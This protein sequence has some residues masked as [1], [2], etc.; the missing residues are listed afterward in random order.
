MFEKLNI[1]HFY[2]AHVTALSKIV[3]HRQEINAINVFPVADAD[4]GNNMAATALAVIH[5]ATMANTLKDTALNMAKA[6]L[7]GARGNSGMIFSQY[8]SGM[9]EA[10]DNEIE[11]DINTFAN[12]ITKAAQ[13][14]RMAI[15][16]PVE[17][18][19]LTLMERFAVLL[20]QQ[21]QEKN[22]EKAI[23][24]CANELKNTLDNTKNMLKILHDAN[25]VDAGALGFYE[26][27]LGMSEY[28]SHPKPLDRANI[29]DVLVHEH[30]ELPAGDEPPKYRYC[31]ELLL[32]GEHLDR[33]A[34]SDELSH[35]GDSVVSS[36][37]QSLCRFHLH[38]NQPHQVFDF[39]RQ[40]GLISRPKIDD[41][42]RQFQVA[43]HKKH[44]I[45]LM[46]DSSA[47][48]PQ[49][50]IDE[51]Q[52]HVLSLNMH[53]DNHDLLDK[54]C[55]DQSHFYQDLAKLKHYPG[56]SFPSPKII[57]D[58]INQVAAHY[59][60]LIILPLSRGLS[61][62][63]DAIVSAAANQHH[64]HVIDSKNTS[65]GLGLLVLKAARLIQSGVSIDNIIDT[66]KHDIT[67]TH[68]FVY[69]HQM[70]G[71]LRSGRIGRLGAAIA[72]LANVKPIISI[73]ANG[74]GCIM[75]KAFSENGALTKIIQKIIEQSEQK[76]L[77]SYCIVHAGA[78]EKAKW[79]SH[80]AEEAFNMKPLFIEPVSTALGLHAGKDS[81]AIAAYFGE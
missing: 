9:A 24:F 56:T 42:L 64:I 15:I 33:Q 52:I 74:K 53:L 55:V 76:P 11:L 70:Q 8:F 54:L 10:L 39:M 75:G 4:T 72:K 34:I 79:L 60:H 32:K 78:P 17:G 66:L 41:M 48:L 31:T 62:T 26:F 51:Y 80:M 46:T 63:H 18:T 58:K 28:L 21:T 44:S 22:F 30:H 2:Y 23:N 3:E 6:A 45:G 71:L 47:D 25:V 81:V 19:I 65:G 49:S 20:T 59:D 77:K 68:I 12:M 40:K 50:L 7:S 73:D 36:G 38:C 61:G 13:S 27:V 1:E 29:T 5:E 16:E 43:H 67:H 57:E 14:V 37:N 69:V 35:Y